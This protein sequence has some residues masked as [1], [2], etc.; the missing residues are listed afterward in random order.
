MRWM[1]GFMN[2]LYIHTTRDCRHYSAIADLHAFQFIVT[3]ELGF[4]VFRSRILATDLLQ[5][6]CNFKS[7]MKS[8]LHR[9]FPFHALILLL[10]IPKTRLSSIPLLPSSYPRR[11]ASRSSTLHSRLL[12][13]LDYL[14]A[15]SDCVVL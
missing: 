8:S 14:V 6:S 10:L 7:H 12:T 13:L 2:T 4:S 9:L 15:S 11:L 5:S 3:Q 1:I